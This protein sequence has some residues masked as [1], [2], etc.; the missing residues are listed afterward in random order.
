VTKAEIHDKILSNLHELAGVCGTCGA[1]RC[2]DRLSNSVLPS[3]IYTED[4]MTAINKA[5]TEKR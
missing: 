2:P 1:R 4:V 5:F 3:R